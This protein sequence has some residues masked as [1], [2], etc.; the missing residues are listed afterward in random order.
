MG[1]ENAYKLLSKTAP[2]LGINFSFFPYTMHPAPTKEKRLELLQ[3]IGVI[4][5]YVIKGQFYISIKVTGY[6]P[7]Q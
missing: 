2:I 4:S 6:N 5:C 1:F 3:K 7:Q